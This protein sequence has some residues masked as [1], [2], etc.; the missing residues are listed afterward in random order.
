MNDLAFAVLET[1]VCADVARDCVCDLTAARDE[2]ANA[3][4]AHGSAAFLNYILSLSLSLPL[5]PPFLSL[6]FFLP[7]AA[8]PF[9]ACSP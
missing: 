5:P 3:G 1:F 7:W 4:G 8:G 9:S 2:T 6:L